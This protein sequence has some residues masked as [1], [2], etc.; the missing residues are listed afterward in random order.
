MFTQLPRVQ[1]GY[2]GVSI[3]GRLPMS[4]TIKVATPT[5]V[6]CLVATATSAQAIR[7]N[8]SYQ[9]VNGHEI[10]TPYC[11]DNALAAVARAH[12]FDVSDSTIRNNPTRKSEICRWIG[13][14]IRT[15]PACEEVLPDGDGSR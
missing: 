11:R 14:D 6:V 8:G 3:N 4:S 1:A 10:S 12:G 13:S 7:C 5:L 15:R 9:V 2:L